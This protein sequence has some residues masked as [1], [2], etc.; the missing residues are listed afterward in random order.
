MISLTLLYKDLA[1]M[2]LQTN[3]LRPDFNLAEEL[4]SLLEE[5]RSSYTEINDNRLIKI[6]SLIN[7]YLDMLK[8]GLNESY[9]FVNFLTNAWEVMNE[10]A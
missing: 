5:I 8:L 6:C 4:N 3:S 1:T 9:L 7:K 10:N 2:L